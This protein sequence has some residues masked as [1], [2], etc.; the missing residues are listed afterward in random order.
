MRRRG[1]TAWRGPSDPGR[2]LNPACRREL[3]AKDQ[4][5]LLRLTS[6]LKKLGKVF[7]FYWT[8][9]NVLDSSAGKDYT[10]TSCLGENFSGLSSRSS[11]LSNSTCLFFFFF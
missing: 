7:D 4:G 3:W 5:I 1:I 11:P 10:R 9:E 6:Y 8:G 2:G